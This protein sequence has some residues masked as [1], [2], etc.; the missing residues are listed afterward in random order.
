[1]LGK[2]IGSSMNFNER[3]SALLYAPVSPL[4]WD[5]TLRECISI[6]ADNPYIPSGFLWILE[7]KRYQIASARGDRQLA[8]T[9]LRTAISLVP[10]E[11]RL[12]GEYLSLCQKTPPVSLL[13]MIV[14]EKDDTTRAI[15]LASQLEQAGL[16]YILL[17]GAGTSIHHARAVRVCVPENY[18]SRARKTVAGLI[19]ILENIGSG[20]GVLRLSDTLSVVDSA[21]LVDSIR[22]WHEKGI[23]AGVPMTMGSEHDRCRHWGLCEDP[24]LNTLPYARPY[25]RTW[26]EEDAYFIPP[27]AL[28]K[29][30]MNLTRFPAQFDGE[31]YEDKLVGDTLM[32]EGI[33]LSVQESLATMG[34]ARR[35]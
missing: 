13:A 4:T 15:E 22:Q 12:Q 17:C 23:Y 33:E 6:E 8:L 7:Y 1:M 9:H 35:A 27:M 28:E 10:Y 32:F 30:V 25:Y 26:A 20:V 3:A 14:V 16:D 21:I 19:W 5:S 11:E 34:L 29:L 24:V 31:Y 18:E 2:L